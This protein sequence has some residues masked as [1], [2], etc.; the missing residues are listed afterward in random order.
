MAFGRERLFAP[1]FICLCGTGDGRKSSK[2]HVCA[3]CSQSLLLA[4]GWLRWEAAGVGVGLVV[5]TCV[6]EDLFS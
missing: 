1:N 4:G 6:S 2:E 5:L 3:L